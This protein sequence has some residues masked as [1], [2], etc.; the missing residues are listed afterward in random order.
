MDLPRLDETAV[1]QLATN[2]AFSRGRDYY[3]SGWVMSLIRRGHTF[4]AE[5]QG[6]DYDPYEV[7]FTFNNE[8]LATTHC[9]CPY[10][11]DGACMH[12]VAA[13]LTYIH[14]PETIEERP[15]IET[16]L[17]SL[18]PGQLKG[19]LQQLATN[20]PG[21]IHFI[22]GQIS[23]LFTTPEPVPEPVDLPAISSENS[24]TLKTQ[25][26]LS[27]T[28]FRQQVRATLH[29]LDHIRPAQEY[30]QVSGIVDQLYELLNQAQVLIGAGYGRSALLILDALTEEY[31][32]KWYDLDGANGEAG[33]FFAELGQPLAEALLSAD[34]TAAE[35]QSWAERLANWQ[36]EVAYYGVDDAFDLAQAA[37]VQGWHYPPLQRLLQ[38]ETTRLYGPEEERPWYADELAAA[39]L[40]VLA[41]QGRYQE[42]LYLAKAE[43]QIEQYVTM[44]VRMGR[45]QEAIAYGLK[46]LESATP[47]LA[48]AKA[49]YEKGAVEAALQ[50][51]E[52]GLSLQ[53]ELGTRAALALWL[54]DTAHRA[55]QVEL[56]FRMSELVFREQPTLANY[57]T[58]RTLAGNDWPKLR[59]DLLNYLRRATLFS[60]QNRVEIFLHEGLVEDAI[61][62]LDAE[63]HPYYA[64]VERVADAAIVS[65]PDWVIRVCCQRAEEILEQ[66]KANQEEAVISWLTRARSAYVAA[67]RQTEWVAYLNRL[68]LRYASRPDML[69]ARLQALH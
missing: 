6:N 37:A 68:M 25:T 28:P 66:D 7:T 18:E 1:R 47:A 64:L 38:G 40:N 5:I 56:A 14:K 11:W 33:D 43:N 62:A 31:V 60:G 44:L 16:L 45:I 42:Y 27:F 4:Y 19:L 10:A 20:Q 15:T 35:R 69:F 51:A 41:R 63:P 36:A 54:R 30:A 57:Q 53:Q 8:G 9:S 52:R 29:D 13:L 21:I 49:L 65:H 50:V 12:V 23:H 55:G 3:E 67:K 24:F 26:N 22:E 32:T 39:R 48:L 58:A 46:K 17:D 59:E 34:L 2:H 61:R